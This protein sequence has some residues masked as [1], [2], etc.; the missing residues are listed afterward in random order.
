M[1][2]LGSMLVKGH[3]RVDICGWGGGVGL[4]RIHCDFKY[5][6]LSLAFP[7][8]RHAMLLHVL[9]HVHT[10]VMLPNLKGRFP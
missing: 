5:V 7:H 2:F 1:L 9:L 6:M 10:Y 4:G 3:A 8:V